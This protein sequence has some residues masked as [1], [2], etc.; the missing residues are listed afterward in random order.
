MPD[1]PIIAVPDI[2]GGAQ[3]L[4]RLL[5]LVHRHWPSAK[6]VFLGNYINHGPD[7]ADVLR[8]VRQHVE[9][10]HIALRG[11]AEETL[12]DFALGVD[13]RLLSRDA[14]G[15]QTLRSIEREAGRW[16]DEPASLASYLRQTGI[17]DW[18]ENLPVFW[19]EGNLV[20]SPAPVPGDCWNRKGE[21]E[22]IL[23]LNGS[24]GG[25]DE[26]AYAHQL[27]AP[28]DCFAVCGSERVLPRRHRDGTSAPIPDAKTPVIAFVTD[29]GDILR[30]GEATHWPKDCGNFGPMLFSHGLYLD[31]GCGSHDDGPLVAAILRSM[32]ASYTVP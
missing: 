23:A 15:W 10:G 20:F 27:G 30:A 8:I 13:E 4:E 29:K 32:A 22:R 9:R 12:L 21:P 7:S 16:F 19:R 24:V 18:L 11:A 28:V 1:Q 31:C 3:R 14:G 2:H 25:L 26:E 6:L 17:L 5:D